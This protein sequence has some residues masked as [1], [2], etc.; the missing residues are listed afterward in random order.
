MF[1]TQLI[2]DIYTTHSKALG[3]PEEGG[4]EQ[5][6]QKKKRRATD[7]MPSCRH[8]PAIA[9][10]STLLLWLSTLGLYETVTSQSWVG[11][12]PTG[13]WATQLKDS[14]GRKALSSHVC[15]VV[16]LTSSSGGFH[17]CDHTGSTQRVTEEKGMT[18]GK[19]RLG[20]MGCWKG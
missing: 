5:K 3:T 14:G 4:E 7:R 11:E 15:P 18:L 20:R 12:G 9:V 8:D 1:K 6:S 16:S 13:C 10:V 17:T 2:E 19:E